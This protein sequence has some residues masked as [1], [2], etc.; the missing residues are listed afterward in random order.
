M[1][2]LKPTEGTKP[3]KTYKIP[4]NR[5]SY[6]KSTITVEARS[7]EEAEAHAENVAHTCHF[8]EYLLEYKVDD[9]DF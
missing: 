4:L 5:I 2:F 3:M 9:L 8:E 6:S 1:D 7:R